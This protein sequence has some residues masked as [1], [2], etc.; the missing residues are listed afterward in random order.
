[1]RF[2]IWTLFVLPLFSP[3][4]LGDI[5]RARE[6]GA[7]SAIAPRIGTGSGPR[8]KIKKMQH[9]PFTSM[10]QYETHSAPEAIRPAPR[11][12]Q[13]PDAHPARA[14]PAPPYP[15]GHDIKAKQASRDREGRQAS[16]GQ[17]HRSATPRP[18]SVK[19][20]RPH[21]LHPPTSKRWLKT[22]AWYWTGT[23]SQRCA[24]PAR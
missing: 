24:G 19:R 2:D 15:S 5:A 1:M 16:I 3:A 6:G 9:P 13:G 18:S 10:R 7:G 22:P 23:R 17:D 21:L 11:A 14:S 20:S 12:Q 4:R 8:K